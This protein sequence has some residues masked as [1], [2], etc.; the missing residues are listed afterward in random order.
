MKAGRD[1]GTLRLAVKPPARCADHPRRQA[2][3]EMA[4]AC[5]NASLAPVTVRHPARRSVQGTRH[6]PAHAMASGLV[7]QTIER[8]GSARTTMPAATARYPL[9]R[10]V[11]DNF[12]P[13]QAGPAIGRLLPDQPPGPRTA[14]FDHLVK[15][16]VG[17][18]PHRWHW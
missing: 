1:P 5:A 15:G 6:A 17:V 13:R 9:I 3:S 18:C 2:N 16:T 7:G 4:R 10:Q 14:A 11:V 8:A 12:F